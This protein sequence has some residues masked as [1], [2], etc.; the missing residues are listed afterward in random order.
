MTKFLKKYNEIME[1]YK[2]GE[3]GQNH[4]AMSDILEKAG[5]P[6]LFN[7]MNLSELQYLIDY[8]SGMT[9]QMFCCVK[10]QREQFVEKTK[11]LEDELTSYGIRQHFDNNISDADLAEK[12]KLDVQYF[13]STDMPKDVEATLSP[14]IDENYV[15]TIKI[16]KECVNKFSY[17]HEIM[18]Y[19]RD[20]GVGNRVLCEY[21]RKK[22]GKTDSD[23]EQEINYLAAAAVMPLEKL[24]T[25]LD[26]YE[27][28][29]CE[30][31]SEFLLQ[32]AEKYG[33]DVNAISRRFAE[34]RCLI[35]AGYRV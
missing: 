26:D 18:H 35:D 25:N 16:L 5:V 21:T 27:S 32:M 8:T 28:I 14:S 23:E 1:M 2:R 12:L 34:V 19:F 10:I 13:D 17:M 31:E 7:K 24:V 22:K 3:F 29:D 9:K 6:D 20:V 11:R 30:Q 4:L 15:G 33:Q